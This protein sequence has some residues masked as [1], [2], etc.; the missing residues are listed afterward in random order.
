VFVTPGAMREFPQWI[1]LCTDFVGSN[2]CYKTGTDIHAF[3][4]TRQQ[5]I[6]E[7]K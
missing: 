4:I 6:S 1:S 7:S 3:E 2:I 5:S